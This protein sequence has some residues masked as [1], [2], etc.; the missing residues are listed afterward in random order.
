M[1]L[2]IICL[3]ITYGI[4]LKN[5]FE[6]CIFVYVL[7]AWQLRSLA[8]Q[9]LPGA[10]LDEMFFSPIFYRFYESRNLYT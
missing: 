4:T 6:M 7:E 3:C 10:L 2:Q 5:Y 8:E 9:C 1:G